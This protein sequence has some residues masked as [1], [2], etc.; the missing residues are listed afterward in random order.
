MSTLALAPAQQ[1]EL[2]RQRVFEVQ[3]A[4]SA[5]LG[6]R[7]RQADIGDWLQVSARILSDLPEQAQAED[8][9]A[10]QAVFFRAQALIEQFIV[11]RGEHY[12]LDDW[13]H[14][15]ARVYRSLEP[16]GQG[17]P[18]SAAQR[19]ARQASLYGSRFEVQTPEPTRTVF[20]NRHCAIWDYRERA[21]A[22]GVPI[23]L[24]SACT[25]CTKL[26]TAFVAARDCQ[27]DYRLYEDDSGHS[28]V[29][30][31]TPAALG[32]PVSRCDGGSTH[33]RD[34]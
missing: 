13:A 21:R 25:Y 6:E 19:L 10:W 5:Y 20:H 2:W 30:T 28:C 34:H 29:W 23:T 12:R 16:H 3:A 11:Q 17:Q 32:A 8:V 15:T 7:Q 1:A 4:M 22:R 27:A 9:S 24:A 18:A 33:E 14:A 26:L 31:I